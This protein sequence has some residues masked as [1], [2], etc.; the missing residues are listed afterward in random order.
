MTLRAA[1]T[2]LAIAIAVPQ[3]G[4]PASAGGN[5]DD[6]PCV[7]PNPPGGATALRGTVAVGVQNAAAT[8]DTD[9]DFTLRLER[10]GAL[11][12]FRAS[13]L[14]QV[15]AR[16]NEGIL[17]SLLNED[18]A[19]TSQAA[20]DLR[21]AIL[22]SFGFPPT[23]VFWLVEKSVSKA[24]IQGTVGQWLCNNT[25]TNPLIITPPVCTSGPPTPRGSSMADVLIYVK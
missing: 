4:M 11:A 14:M 1:I 5:A 7:L 16:S 18:L 21:A 17:C 24:E 25:W 20:R 12:F 10:G 3:S 9:V 22:R 23:A 19:T 2:V 15:F 6:P 13:V 8:G